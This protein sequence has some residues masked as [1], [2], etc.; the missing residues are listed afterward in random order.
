MKL[1]DRDVHHH[2]GRAGR[3]RKSN[4]VPPKLN[5]YRS[6]SATRLESQWNEEVA[7]MR[8]WAARDSG[9]IS[10]VLHVHNATYVDQKRDV[11][12]HRGVSVLKQGMY[13]Q[14]GGDGCKPSRDG[15]I[16]VH[17]SLRVNRSPA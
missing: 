13:T 4:D 9:S 10:C 5:V 6:T 8:G 2:I 14:D 17:A 16:P 11:P 3:D 12:R 7:L 15:C 1:W